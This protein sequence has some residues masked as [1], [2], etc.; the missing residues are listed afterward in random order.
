MKPQQFQDLLNAVPLLSSQQRNTLINALS[1]QNSP[2]DIAKSIEDSFVRAPK[3]PHC[4]SEALQRWGKRNKRQ[5]FRCKVCR[6][7]LNAFSKTPLARLRRPEAW[8]K[9]LEGMTHSLTLRPAAKQC[10][11]SL[12]TSF[13]WRHR[14]LQVIEHDQAPEL[15]GIAEL[16]ETFFRESFKGQ[17][18]GLPR[19]VR[20]RGSDKK[21]DCRKIP[22]MVASS[23]PKTQP[24]ENCRFY[25]EK[26]S[27]ALLLSGD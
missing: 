18:K 2:S 22:V 6:K 24:I 25:S 17:K 15:S 16:D 23:R 20:K 5:R 8:P 10:G 11:V 19:P 4:G 27:G 14:F 3:C 12:N 13:R 1:E 7:T 9:Y 21:T 26:L